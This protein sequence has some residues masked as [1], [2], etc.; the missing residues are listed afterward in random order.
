MIRSY[1][2]CIGIDEAIMELI[3]KF[4]NWEPAVKN[5]VNVISM[6]VISIRI[7]SEQ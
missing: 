3:D 5:G 4:P 1:P 6:K 2:L 7:S